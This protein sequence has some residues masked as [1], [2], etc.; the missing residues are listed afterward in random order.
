MGS[1]MKT[2]I[3]TP[4]VPDE[5]YVVQIDGRAKSGHRRFMDALR[6]AL[7][8]KDQFPLQDVKVRASNEVQ[9][10]VLH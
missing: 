6:E 4:S 2:A 1:V 5:Y 10:T 9:R 8:L 3:T 7:V